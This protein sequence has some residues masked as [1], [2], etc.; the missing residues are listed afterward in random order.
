M[1]GWGPDR[2]GSRIAGCAL[3]A[4]ALLLLAATERAARLRVAAEDAVG[5]FVLTGADAQPGPGVEGGLVLVAGTPQVISLATDLQFAVAASAPAL[6]RKVEMFQ[7]REIAFGGGAPSYELDWVD[8]AVDSSRFR[9]PRG[10]E[11]PGAFPFEGARFYA[12]SVRLA[13]YTLSLPLLQAI[14]G[15]E[16]YA[17]DLS[18]LPPNLAA[19]FQAVEGALTTSADPASPRLGDLRVSWAVVPLQP[20]TVVARVRNGTLVPAAGADGVATARVQLGERAPADM[21]PDMP[22]APRY[23]WARRALV[24]LLAWGGAMLL[25]NGRR[26]DEIA[27]LLAATAPLAAL[28]GALWLDTRSVAAVALFALAALAGGGA[29]LRLKRPRAARPTRR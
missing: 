14:P 9:Q 16:A 3:L 19:S 11:N 26:R 5:G 1:I 7:W 22:E 21:L 29:L 6:V 25:L 24:L 18:R 13:G 15:Y 28:G 17:P 10:H 20:I 12:P 27:A 8:R 23:A 2:W 4:L